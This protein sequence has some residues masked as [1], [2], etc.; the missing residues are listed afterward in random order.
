MIYIKEGILSNELLP[1]P[2]FWL[3]KP[4]G[5]LVFWG[6]GTALMKLLGYFPSLSPF[7]AFPFPVA[8]L[9]PCEGAQGAQT[10]LLSELWHLLPH[11]SPL[12]SEPC[13][14]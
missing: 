1:Q 6:E 4:C 2:V 13:S 3:D 5:E 11:P 10:P 9:C 8:L 12:P 14:G 7:A